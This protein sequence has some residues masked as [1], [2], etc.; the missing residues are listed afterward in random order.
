MHIIFYDVSEF[1]SYDGT[2]LYVNGASIYHHEATVLSI[3]KSRLTNAQK[4]LKKQVKKN[5]S[6]KQ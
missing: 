1:E 5:L 2:F 6:T 4:E 3:Y